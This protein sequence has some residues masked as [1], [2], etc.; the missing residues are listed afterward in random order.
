MSLG[1]YYDLSPCKILPSP[2]KKVCG[3]PWTGLE[4]NNFFYKI[5]PRLRVQKQ[6][7]KRDNLNAF[8]DQ[9]KIFL[10]LSIID[11]IQH[12][13]LFLYSNA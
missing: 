2:G 6:L 12:R 13:N 4:P 9:R 8:V 10:G 3:R 7:K 1:K 5:V 11:V